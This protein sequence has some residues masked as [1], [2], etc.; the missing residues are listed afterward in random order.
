MF[1]KR[2]EQF[3]TATVPS[4]IFINVAGGDPI[5]LLEKGQVLPYEKTFR[6]QF[7]VSGVDNGMSEI[8][9]MRLALF[10]APNALS[11]R[12]K[13][14]K[15]ARIEFKKPIKK[16][17]KLVLKVTCDKERDVKLRAWLDDDSTEMLEVHIGANEYSEEETNRMKEMHSTVSV[18]GRLS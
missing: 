14:L 10:T 3:H 12:T 13:K 16:N 7:Y 6:D 11:I 17:S 8:T 15:E 9:T 2:R 18:V 1:Q 4:N 5:A